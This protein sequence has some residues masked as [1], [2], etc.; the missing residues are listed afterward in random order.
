MESRAKKV[1]SGLIWTYA[2]RLSAQLITIIVTI[3][4]A[5]VLAPSESGLIAIVSIF[6][7]IA[8][9]FVINGFGNSLIQ[10]K[11]ADDIDFS[12]VLY[13]SIAFSTILYLMLFLC[14]PYIAE[15][16]E[17][18]ALTLIVRIMGLRLP[19]AA[20]NS[21]QQAYVSKKM[22]FKKFFFA[23]LGGTLVSGI[24]GITMAYCGCGIWALVVQYLSNVFIDTIVLCLTSGWKPQMV[25]SRKRM[26]GLF[27]YGWKVMIVGVMTTV[28]SNI[29]NLV[30]GKKYTSAD[31]AYSEKGELFPSAIAGNINSSITKVLFP[32]LAESQND[33]VMVLKMVRRSIR[34]GT[35]L[36]FPIMFGFA[37]VARPFVILFLTDKWAEC[38]PFLQIMCIV[39]ALQPLQTS[40]LQCVKALGK[41][42]LY[43]LIDIVKKVIGILILV[44]TVIAF[45]DVL[46]IV[47]GAL[48]LEIVSVIIMVIVN[49]KIIDYKYKEQV[50]DILPTVMLTAIMCGSVIT[51]NHF[52]GIPYLVMLIVDVII[53]IGIYV[54]GSICFKNENYKYILS[55]L[56]SIIRKRREGK[57]DSSL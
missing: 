38:I 4:L 50:M 36:L 14:A 42:T 28:Y 44:T 20:I 57:H 37:A 5:R 54:G 6:I 8:N 22:M 23:T 26:K 27:S 33:K 45:N 18:E 52:V 7:N 29:R 31:L 3:V 51:F 16:Y 13:F 34:I 32:V 2:E 1:T 47:I 41:G 30:I 11:E 15:F 56:C 53:G 24:V 17:E 55:I 10:K 19:L 21:V 9:A 46:I 39:Y 35:Y 12:T 40:S 43:L 49:R 48:V 25:Y